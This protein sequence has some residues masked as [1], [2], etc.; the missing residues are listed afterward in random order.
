MAKSNG[1]DVDARIEALKGSA[2][3]ELPWQS[4]VAGG[5]V[6]RFSTANMVPEQIEAYMGALTEAGF[7]PKIHESKSLG[8]TIRLSGLEAVIMDEAHKVA[9]PRPGPG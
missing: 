1:G 4:A 2:L 9:N 5:L 6:T 3:A 8:P 7:H